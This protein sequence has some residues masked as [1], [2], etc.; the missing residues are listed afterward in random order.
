MAGGFV[1][2]PAGADRGLAQA[3]MEL[4]ASRVG[5]ARTA[6]QECRRDYP[7]RAHRSLVLASAAAGTDLAETW[8][9]EDPQNTDAKLLYARVAMV[10]ALRSRETADGRES[11]LALMA[12]R[13]AVAAIEAA[14]WDPTPWS[15]LIAVARRRPDVDRARPFGRTPPPEGLDALGPWD[16]LTEAH[17]RQPW[18][19]E[20]YH[21]MLTYFYPRYGGDSDGLWQVAH[22]AATVSPPDSDA[23]LLP[24]VAQA[25][26]ARSGAASLAQEYLVHT[27]D[28]LF[29]HW[30]LGTKHL[31]FPPIADLSLLAH[32]LDRGGRTA[33]TGVVLEHM[34]P[35]ATS[36]PW[37][38]DGDPARVLASAYARS[39]I[40]PP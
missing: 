35:Y 20:S 8:L 22:W 28:R 29:A 38:L 3:V 12:W 19:R 34:S 31:S 26:L 39:R 24:L 15:V 23:Q 25:E 37:S 9:E 33:D 6:M 27:A 11:G 7:V 4:K 36:F 32:A 13:A 21:R 2:D 5:L 18:H 14:P 40:R 17:A 10:R 1:W 16:L 30:F